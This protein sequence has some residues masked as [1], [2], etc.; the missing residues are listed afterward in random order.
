MFDGIE[1]TAKTIQDTC[2]NTVNL[3]RV[4]AADRYIN[5]MLKEIKGQS[6]RID[7]PNLEN[8]IQKGYITRAE[9]LLLKYRYEKRGFKAEVI[10]WKEK[11]PSDSKITLIHWGISIEA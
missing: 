5:N 9:I 8:Y 4:N 1:I 6:F 2:D 10:Q 3:E 7:I 11:Y